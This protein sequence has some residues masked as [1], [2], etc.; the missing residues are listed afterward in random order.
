[1]PGTRIV[2]NTFKI[3]D[4]PP[5]E[6]VR[7]ENLSTLWCDLHLYIVPAQVAGNW[8]L[9]QGELRLAQVYQTV[10]GTL[11]SDGR[12]VSIEDGRLHGD[13]IRFRAGGASYEGRVRD[14]VMEGSVKGGPA[15]RWSAD[16]VTP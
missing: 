4:W 12:V 3:D 15:A 10:S 6:T 13:V 2:S 8:R 14:N 9:A 7:V 5:D 11:T 16:R 1:K